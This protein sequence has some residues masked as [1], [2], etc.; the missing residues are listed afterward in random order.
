MKCQLTLYS[1]A[2]IIYH[3]QVAEIIEST[4]AAL[5][6]FLADKSYGDDLLEIRIG[7]LC[8]APDFEVN[9]PIKRPRYLRGKRIFKGIIMPYTIENYLSYDIRVPYGQ[10]YQSHPEQLARLFT[11]TLI[12]SFEHITQGQKK[13]PHF[14]SRTFIN[15]VSHFLNKDTTG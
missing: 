7:V 5:E 9:Y 14:D 1:T 15:D 8:M 4:N 6:A 13:Y 3:S 11:K 12:V 2:D 10:A